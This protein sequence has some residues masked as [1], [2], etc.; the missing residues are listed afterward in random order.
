MQFHARYFNLLLILLFVATTATLV[1]L[2]FLLG[3]FEA[4]GDREDYDISHDRRD[5]RRR[6]GY[7]Y[8]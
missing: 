6:R 7:R 2:K 1:L 4:H 3:Y 8:L 5:D